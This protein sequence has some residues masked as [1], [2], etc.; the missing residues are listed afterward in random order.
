MFWAWMGA[1]LIGTTLG[2]LGSGGSILTVPVLVYLLGHEQKTAI[3]ES[4]AVVGAIAVAGTVFYARHRCVDWPSVL[5]FGL[6]GVAGTYAGAWFSRFVPG[7]VQL[8]LFAILMLSA[9]VFVWSSSDANGSAGQAL[10]NRTTPATAQQT[11]RTRG[12]TLLEGLA[13]GVVTGL[14]GV[15]GGFLIV[16]SLVVLAGLPMRVAV[17]T[18]LTIIAM[19]SGSGFLKYLGVLKELDLHVDWQTI[20]LFTAVG[21]AGAVVGG[22]VNRRLSQRYLRK[23][24]AGLLVVAAVFILGREIP[25]LM[26]HSVRSTTRQVVLGADRPLEMSAGVGDYGQTVPSAG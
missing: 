20:G 14:V 19:N 8:V 7:P 10:E 25:R 17:G 21:M 3:A 11:W 1:L 2:L 9:A 5:Y 12:I 22:A 15:G 26:T 23:L 16:P 4:L 13:V 24:F 18:S 6:P